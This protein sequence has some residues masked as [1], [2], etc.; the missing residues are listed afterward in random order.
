M[1]FASC[2]KWHPS[3]TNCLGFC[4]SA[5]SVPTQL[6]RHSRRDPVRP[7]SVPVIVE[8]EHDH[9][10]AAKELRLV[11]IRGVLLQSVGRIEMRIE[12]GLVRDQEVLSRGCRLLHHLERRHH[13]RRD[14]LHGRAGLAGNDF[15]DG[16]GTPGNADVC[17][18]AIDDLGRRQR[19]LRCRQRTGREERRSGQ[20]AARD[21]ERPSRDFHAGT[22]HDRG[23][24]MASL[25]K[26]EPRYDVEWCARRMGRQ[27][28]LD[29]PH[30]HPHRRLRHHR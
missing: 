15:V 10:V 8:T 4:W 14:A 3:S 29:I 19:R 30:E 13:R 28:R 26:S 22:Q 9:V 24:L 5:F 7:V 2:A 16:L 21:K 1:S 27:R 23:I 20:A 25:R 6:T 11:A 12:R 17:L 18:D